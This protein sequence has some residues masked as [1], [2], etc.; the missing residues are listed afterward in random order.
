MPTSVRSL[1]NTLGKQE[2]KIVISS[3]VGLVIF[4]CVGQKFRQNQLH[5]IAESVK[6][7]GQEMLGKIWCCM[8]IVLTRANP[9]LVLCT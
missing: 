9:L 2:V 5:I 1:K 4:L 6:Y 7:P 8:Y 3:A